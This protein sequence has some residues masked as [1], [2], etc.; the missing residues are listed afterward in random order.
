MTERSFSLHRATVLRG[1]VFALSLA[2]LVPRA[3][4]QSDTD[5][6]TAMH[7]GEAELE[8]EH[9]GEARAL[10]L[11][12]LALQ[13]DSRALVRLG[14][15]EFELREYGDCVTHLRA[16]LADTAHPVRAAREQVTSLLER[17]RAFVGEYRLEVQPAGATLTVDDE[18][19]PATGSLLLGIGAHTLVLRAA[20]YEELR[21]VVRTA[22]GED[23]AL[24][25]ALTAST[26]TSTTATTSETQVTPVT[27]AEA[28]THAGS[29][30][31]PAPPAPTVR[32][33]VTSDTPGLVLHRGT[34]RSVQGV[35]TFTA[36]CAAPCDAELPA[37]NYTL[38][39]GTSSDSAQIADHSVFTFDHDT[40]VHLSYESRDGLRI[41]GGVGGLVAFFGG[42]GLLVGG[43]ANGG[44]MGSLTA[45]A[46]TGLEVS[47]AIL[48]TASL[49]VG[50]ALL[51]LTDVADVQREE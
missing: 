38:G 3:H 27:I 40:G 5:Y 48:M 24:A 34:G 30:E 26:T 10:F 36:V 14:Q 4:A 41:A 31:P 22:G 44:D 33:H 7:D 43:F 35:T 45:D 28:P 16:A 46:A 11:R 19:R 1:L 37:G 2:A 12:A 50:M 17:A 6:R 21:R 8:A 39:V 42:V 20:G 18:P 49:V 47:G 25:L 9:Y 23:E 29:N 15:T 51:F 13:N 32:V